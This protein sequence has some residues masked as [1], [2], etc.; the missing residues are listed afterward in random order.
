MTN[1]TEVTPK[2]E[3]C[4][5]APGV[6]GHG[7]GVEYDG[8]LYYYRVGQRIPK[9]KVVALRYE[10]CFSG[11]VHGDKEWIIVACVSGCLNKWRYFVLRHAYSEVSKLLS[12]YKG[13]SPQ[14]AIDKE[15]KRLQE[16]EQQRDSLPKCKSCG[17]I[18]IKLH[19]SH[20]ED[21]CKTCVNAFEDGFFFVII[22]REKNSDKDV[23]R[24]RIS[25][26]RAE[27]LMDSQQSEVKLGGD[28]RVE[29]TRGGPLQSALY[30]S[31]RRLDNRYDYFLATEPAVM[32][33]SAL[34]P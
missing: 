18:N 14:D 31:K 27:R 1:L 7:E 29:L 24:I 16:S 13:M 5:N 23:E 12:E 21:F 34:S 30:D 4:P 26:W 28:A 11:R 8:K 10:G 19:D 20:N 15:R 25:R 32:Q 17:A 22:L 2:I 33:A 9:D 3:P 6:E